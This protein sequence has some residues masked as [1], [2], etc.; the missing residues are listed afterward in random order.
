[1]TRLIQRLLN[2][3]RE[4]LS[5][6]GLLFAYLFLVIA[7][8]VVGKAARSALFLGKYAAV[9]LPYVTITIA[10]MVGLVVAVYVRI[11]RAT[12]LR[13]LLVGSLAL[14]AV[15]ALVFWYGAH[16]YKAAW[17]YPAFYIWV[18]IYG[19][20]APAQVWTL[21]NHALTT[22]QAKRL[23]GLVGSGAISGFIFG[24]FLTR[25]LVGRLGVESVL[26]GMTL[27]TAAC[28]DVAD[29]ALP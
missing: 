6:G 22:R 29:V 13:N 14:F 19:V 23:F 20:L 18:G 17:L 15:N 5:R 11:S 16:Y 8:Y 7:S 28:H 4:D 27:L 3:Q 24:G 12:T 9:N 10:I 26:L 2:L 25:Q 1:M 21:T